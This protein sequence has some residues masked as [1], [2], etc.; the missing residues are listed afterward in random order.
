MVFLGSYSLGGME[1]S[2]PA[3][4]AIQAAAVVVVYMLSEL[5]YHAAMKRFT[6]VG[7]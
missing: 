3:I 7:A 6:A 1:M 4:V 5:L 2:I